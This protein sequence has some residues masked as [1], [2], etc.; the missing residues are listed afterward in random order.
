VTAA[1]TTQTTIV[2][3]VFFGILLLLIAATV[4]LSER[5][6]GA[7]NPIYIVFEKALG[8]RKGDPVLVAGVNEGY[9]RE[10][11]LL[12]TAMERTDPLNPAIKMKNR[13]RV[14]CE[15]KRADQERVRFFE[16]YKI[17]VEYA[18]VLGGRVVAMDPGDSSRQPVEHSRDNPLQGRVRPDPL[19][20]LSELIEENRDN[21]KGAI[22]EIKETFKAARSGDG[23]LGKIISDP[24]VARK[25]DKIVNDIERVTDDLA[26]GRG[27]LGAAINDPNIAKQFKEIIKNIDD[28]TGKLNGNEGT[29]G[30]LINDTTWANRVDKITSDI[31]D[32]TGKLNRAEGTLGKLINSDELHARVARIADK[33]EIAIDHINDGTGLLGKIIHDKELGDD[34]K[35]LVHELK[36]IISTVDRGEGTLG[37][38]V[39]DDTLIRQLER[40]IRQISRSIEDAREAAPIATFSSVLFGAF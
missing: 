1:R 37:R 2:G 29:L 30:R 31:S 19:A 32:V 3:I 17:Y 40:V 16:G 8:L 22:I 15:V 24:E 10:I 34:A 12:D 38:L 39:K 20:S 28:V 21:I 5:V 36:D 18:S 26:T 23:L 35:Q 14:R 7:T 25:F 11:E 27:A 6:Y 9:V 33:L 4:F 13:V